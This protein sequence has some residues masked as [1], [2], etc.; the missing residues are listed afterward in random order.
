MVYKGF[1]E[2][3]GG[4][5]SGE[6]WKPLAFGSLHPTFGDTSEEDIKQLNRVLQGIAKE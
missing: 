2:I 1:W 4:N 5:F 3:I 6:A